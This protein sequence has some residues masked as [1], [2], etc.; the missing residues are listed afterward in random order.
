MNDGQSTAHARWT[1]SLADGSGTVSTES[2]AIDGA[3][4]TWKS[5][6][7]ETPGTTPEELL[8]AGHAGCYSMALSGALAKAGHTP[9]Q[10]E[11]D[12]TFRFGPVEGGFGIKGIH[13]TVEGVV[14]GIDE[15]DFLKEAEGAK[16]GCPVSKAFAGNVPIELEAKLLQHA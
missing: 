11:V 16:V 2:P 13:L 1:G 3:Q 10:L 9:E 6:I 15:A 8:A 4:L 7:G 5:R 14:P 12:A